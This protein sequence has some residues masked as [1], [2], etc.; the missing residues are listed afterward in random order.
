MH[1]LSLC[2][3]IADTA[4]EHADG[5]AVRTINLRIGHLRQVV[6]ET[7]VFY[8]GMRVPGTVLDDAELR[9]DEVP[10]VVTCS[11][12]DVNTTLAE[13]VL[14]CGACGCVDV[15]L[16]AGEEFLI[17]SIDLRAVPQLGA[18]GPGQGAAGATVASQERV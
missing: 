11:A 15:R 5:R 1:E 2:R 17:E 7:L 8:W 9:I 18:R 3:A 12:C 6:P 10:A 14:R 16:I 13:P 4:I